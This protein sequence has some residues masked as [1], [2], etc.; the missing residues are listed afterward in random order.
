MNE[1]YR[2]LKEIVVN[3]VFQVR[4][5][6]YSRKLY[7]LLNY[8]G[9]AGTGFTGDKG[10]KG[11]P[12]SMNIIMNIYINKIYLGIICSLSTARYSGGTR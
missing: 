8:L 10:Q 7:P 3:Q 6:T 12:V 11:E 5:K 9:S 2:V 4:R 1:I